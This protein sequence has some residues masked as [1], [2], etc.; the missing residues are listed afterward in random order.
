MSQGQ[1]VAA[2]RSMTAP[3]IVRTGTL[4]G[5]A[6]TAAMLNG[7]APA[8]WY[9]PRP[10]DPRAWAER[11]EQIR[12]EPRAADRGAAKMSHVRI[13]RLGAGDRQHHRGQCDERHRTMLA[14]ELGAVGR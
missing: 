12:Q 9:M 4:G 3:T 10:T 8:H 7:S 11:V 5:G 6:L 13:Q 14:E 2:E 1:L